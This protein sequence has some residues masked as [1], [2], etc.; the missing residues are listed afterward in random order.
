LDPLY[1]VL[2]NEDDGFVYSAQVL[3]DYLEDQG[4]DV[5]FGG[6]SGGSDYQPFLDRNISASGIHTGTCGEDLLLILRVTQ[7]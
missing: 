2:K 6:F 1:G 3:Y 7:N 4:V 5:Y